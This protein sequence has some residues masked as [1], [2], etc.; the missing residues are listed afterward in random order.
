MHPRSGTTRDERLSLVNGHAHLAR[1]VVKRLRGL[2]A[3]QRAEAHAVALAA[4]DVAARR[5]DPKR[6]ASFAGHA[7]VR[8]VWAVLTWWRRETSAHERLRALAQQLGFSETEL[9]TCGAD[10]EA[11]EDRKPLPAAIDAFDVAALTG[12]R[13]PDPER[14][15]LDREAE[16]LEREAFARALGRLTHGQR[17]VFEL[18]YR[19]DLGWA[20][21]AERLF[22]SVSTAKRRDV[23][24]R[25]ALRRALASRGD[26]TPA[27]SGGARDSSAR[28]PAPR[29]LRPR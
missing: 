27:S 14:L 10:D 7:W 22:V 23:E 6:N 2:S 12:S 21:I 26:A 17:R 20:A 18:R 15:L 13:T 24:M 8:M 11:S 3:S 16:E 28:S 9:P 29:P 1:R 19:E 4:L 5:H 25:R